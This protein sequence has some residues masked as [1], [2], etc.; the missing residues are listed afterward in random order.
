MIHE[1]MVELRALLAA[2]GVPLELVDGPERSTSVVVPRERIVVER[3]REPEELLAPKGAGRNPGHAYDRRLHGR[4]TIY[5]QEPRSG[6]LPHEHVRR[7]DDF[8]DSV[9]V[10]LRQVLVARKNGADIGNG[11]L[12]DLEDAKGALV[13]NFAVY[14]IPF[15]VRRATEVRTWAGA[16]APEVTISSVKS[17][18][19][20]SLTGATI[21]ATSTGCG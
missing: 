18:T 13:T 12:V 2:D 5:A 6:A 4:V 10:R 3:L 9:I 15:F 7:V 19:V 14:Q 16:A 21:P 1:I 17:T 20:V 11:R 8:V